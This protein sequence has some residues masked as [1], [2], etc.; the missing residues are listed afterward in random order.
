MRISVDQDA[1]EEGVLQIAIDT[2]GEEAPTFIQ[3]PAGRVN[4]IKSES[5]E[6]GDG[7]PVYELDYD[8]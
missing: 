6:T 1:F 4:I 2:E 3:T 7:K 5:I 8:N